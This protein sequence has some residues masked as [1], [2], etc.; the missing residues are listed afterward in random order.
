[1][2]G[3]TAMVIKKVVNIPIEVSKTMKEMNKQVKEM[4]M[5]KKKSR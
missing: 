4:A 3:V 1:M 5:P 2:K